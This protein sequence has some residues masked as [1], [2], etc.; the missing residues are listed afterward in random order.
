MW[1]CIFGWHGVDGI[2]VSSAAF[3][4][5]LAC[6]NFISGKQKLADWSPSSGAYTEIPEII[7]TL[8]RERCLVAELILQGKPVIKLQ[9]LNPHT[10]H[11]SVALE[12]VSSFNPLVKQVH[13]L[14]LPSYRQTEVSCVSHGEQRRMWI[15]SFGL[16][17]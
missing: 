3:Q 17:F 13:L 15:Q 12:P 8:E 7:S 10:G 11:T 5:I 1:W 4:N 14:P 9:E 6:E 16:D 2:V